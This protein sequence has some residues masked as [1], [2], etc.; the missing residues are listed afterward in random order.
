MCRLVAGDHILAGDEC[1][2]DDPDDCNMSTVE[3][4][5]LKE[6]C[7]E[8][9]YTVN[10]IKEL[11]DEQGDEREFSARCI[12]LIIE[13]GDLVRQVVEYTEPDAGLEPLD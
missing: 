3:G 5:M 7:D 9:I 4:D 1:C 6:A 11:V 13:F 8:I 2:S 10:Q 12:S